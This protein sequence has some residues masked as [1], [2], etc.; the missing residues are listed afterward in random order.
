MADDMPF[1]RRL[2]ELKAE[3]G[4]SV[5][6]IA[7]R[8]HYSKSYVHDLLSGTRPPTP[9]AAR[10]LDDAL[11]AGGEL[12][13]LATL[14]PG[15][16]VGDELDAVELARRVEAS[17]VSDDTLDRLH[18]AFDKL[19]S[20]YAT[21]PPTDL[22]G[23]ARHHLGYV[24]TLM[25]AR[26]TLR[27]RQRL[28]ELG[29]WLSLLAGT[30]HID[31]HQHDAAAARLRTADRLASH[32]EHDEIRAWCL[33]TKAW[34]V[35]TAGDFRAAVNLSQQAQAL[36]PRGSSVEI[37]ATAQEG[38][39]WAR[40]GQQTET[41]QVLERVNRLVSGLERPDQPEHHYKYDPDKAIAYVATTLAWAGDPAA[42]A[43]TRSVVD[44]L[45]AEGTRPRRIASARLDLGLALLAA[46]QPDEAAAVA[47][48]AISSGRVVPSNWW[49]A[50]EVLAGVLT[51][52]I[53]EAADLREAY[54][55][56]RPTS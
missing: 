37:Q 11:D 40:L 31:L 19:A 18:E 10:Q 52:G 2:R 53:A 4:T 51:A 34:E 22:I 43:F 46:D 5:R 7:A 35:L 26:M 50:K 1:A 29:G 24:G 21:T 38:R 45:A 30:I 20:A 9:D 28:V 56:H 15:D 14:G 41:R 6:A 16:E 12:V 23:R 55:A 32:A 44:Q 42:E 33:E 39:A 27:Q 3:R 13:A 25:D 54:E 49:R 17:D 48:D 36:A 47:M 8:A